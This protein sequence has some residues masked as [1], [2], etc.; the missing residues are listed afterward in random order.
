MMLNLPPY[1]LDILSKIFLLFTIYKDSRYIE[2]FIT[3]NKII[4][5]KKQP[6]AKKL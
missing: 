1:L 2:I 3:L 6:I 4:Q 5:L